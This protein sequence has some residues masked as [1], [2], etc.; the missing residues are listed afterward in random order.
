MNATMIEDT[1]ATMNANNN[2]SDED[3]TVF[4]YTYK[5]VNLAYSH[6]PIAK[7][8]VRGSQGVMVEEMKGGEDGEDDKDGAD[9]RSNRAVRNAEIPEKEIINETSSQNPIVLSAMMWISNTVSLLVFSLVVTL[10]VTKERKWFYILLSVFIIMLVA[11]IV[12]I[13]LM[14]YDA[15]FLYRPGMCIGN[16]TILDTFFHDSFILKSTFDKIDR[17]EYYKR[18]FPSMHMTLASSVLALMYLFFPKYKKAILISAPLYLILVGYSR[19]YLSCH[20]LLQVICGIIF[21]TLGA[22]VMYNV[23]G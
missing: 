2:K 10:V 21:G 19:I 18:G 5:D 4:N 3:D 9:M 7:P 8:V 12:K 6:E 22:K 17:I 1:N 14:R 11:Q 15:E 13:I 16:R 23:F 20:T